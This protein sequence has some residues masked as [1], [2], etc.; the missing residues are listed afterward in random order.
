MSQASDRIIININNLHICSGGAQI[1]HYYGEKDGDA[2]RKPFVENDEKLLNNSCSAAGSDFNHWYVVGSGT[3]GVGSIC[4]VS[5]T[6]TG[7]VPNTQ[8]VRGRVYQGSTSSGADPGYDIDATVD[9]IPSN[10][11][12]TWTWTAANNPLTGAA[13]STDGSPNYCAFW[14]VDASTNTLVGFD[15]PLRLFT[16]I[17]LPASVSC[18]LSVSEPPLAAKKTL[19]LYLSDGEQL[20]HSILHQVAPLQWRALTGLLQGK[21]TLRADGNNLIVQTCFGERTFT[22]PRVE[23]FSMVL[24]GDL[25]GSR[26]HVVV[27]AP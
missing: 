16:G 7:A 24:P 23:P 2:S 26:S 25:F 17:P 21:I 27:T 5:I 6:E 15:P 11:G 14:I 18:G 8:K 13:Y 22:I 9:G 20:H 19:E 3:Q 4:K 1:I 10:G 12:Y